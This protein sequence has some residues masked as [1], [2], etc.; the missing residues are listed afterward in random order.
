M[1]V[2]F[3]VE[4]RRIRLGAELRALREAAGIS[5]RGLAAAADVDYAKLSRLENGKV[6]KP[7]A[8]EI[9]RLLDAL[10]VVD[11]KRD[12]ILVLAMAANSRG[13]YKALTGPLFDRHRQ[14]AELESGVVDMRQYST[15]FVP[16]LLQTPAYARSLY[17]DATGYTSAEVDEALRV[18]RTRQALLDDSTFRYKVLLDESVLSRAPCSTVDMADQVDALAALHDSSTVTVRVVRLSSGYRE[19]MPE[20]SFTI[21]RYENP[22][23]LPVAFIE[24]VALDIALD[25][26]EDVAQHVRAF[27]QLWTDALSIDESREVMTRAARTLRRS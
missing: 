10:G 14:V 4:T 23:R 3:P 8:E 15:L 20:S 19:L 21:F 25:D 26:P 16:G 24:T 2:E 6:L 12:D 5:V 27:D 9:G 22:D 17:T 7:N 1:S 13:W 18:R 11:P